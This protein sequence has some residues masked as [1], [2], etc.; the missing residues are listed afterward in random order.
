MEE[1]GLA[2]QARQ[3]QIHLETMAQDCRTHGIQQ[4]DFVKVD[5]EGHEMEVFKGM[6]DLIQ[7]RDI[8]MIQFEYGGCNIDARVFLKDYFAFFVPFG[9]T[10][11]K[12]YPDGLKKVERYDQRLENFQYQNWLV[13]S[14]VGLV[15][16]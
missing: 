8:K 16:N 1:I 3:E 4:V 14:D 6:L 7:S 10:F 12:L 15:P 2:P 11:Y 9:Y 5:V 13:V